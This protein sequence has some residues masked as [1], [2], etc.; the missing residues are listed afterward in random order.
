MVVTHM[1]S[2]FRVPAGSSNALSVVVWGFT[3]CITFEHGFLK[4][5]LVGFG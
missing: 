3:L 4:M 5:R 1:Q 2:L